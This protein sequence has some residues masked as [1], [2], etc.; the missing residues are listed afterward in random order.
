MQ[1]IENQLPLTSLY[2]TI[3]TTHHNIKWQHF[4]RYLTECTKSVSYTH[5][6]VYKRQPDGSLVVKAYWSVKYRPGR[7]REALGGVDVFALRPE[8]AICLFPDKRR[9]R[10][11]TTTTTRG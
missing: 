9:R 7:P 2:L 3:L 4:I 11:T 10:I 1:Y 5:L 6:D 8:Q